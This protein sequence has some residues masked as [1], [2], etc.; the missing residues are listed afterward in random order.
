MNLF[1]SILI[2]IVYFLFYVCSKFKIPIKGVVLVLLGILLYRTGSVLDENHIKW[3]GKE[4]S[5]ILQLVENQ[6]FPRTM[7]CVSNDPLWWQVVEVLKLYVFSEKTMF[8]TINN[9]QNMIIHENSFF[10]IETLSVRGKI[11]DGSHMR[12]K[13]SY[14]CSE[15]FDSYFGR[16]F[17]C[18]KE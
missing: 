7:V 8:S 5:P 9:F 2:V 14:E 13:D 12:I 11:A 4:Y 15:Y 3:S 18:T 6:Q 17:L 10:L 16:G 1:P